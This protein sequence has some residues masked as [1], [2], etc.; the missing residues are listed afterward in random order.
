[1]GAS[2]QTGTLD[3][4]QHNSAVSSQAFSEVT[5]GVCAAKGFAAGGIHAG[6]RK[7][8]ARLDMALV[9]ADAPCAAAGTFTTNRFCAA[10]VQVS[11][12]HLGADVPLRLPA[13]PAL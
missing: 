3:G 10:P 2:E 6:F 4:Q 9:V 13:D 12:A 11:R 7:D 8:P 1:M 5:G